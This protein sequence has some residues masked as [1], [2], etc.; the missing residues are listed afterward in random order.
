MD[1]PRAQGNK[2]ADKTSTQATKGLGMTSESSIKALILAELP[3]L[4]LDSPKYTEAQNQ[5]AKAEGAIK[6][7]K[8]WWE[9]PSGKLLV[10]EG[11]ART[12]VSQTH[13]ATHL[14]HD[15]LEE[16]IQKY[17]LVPPPP[18]FPMPDRISELHCLLT[19]QC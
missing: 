10:P 5:L 1:T 9:L 11:L 17:L 7:E 16:I 13:Q 14:G 6:T 15:K 12:L 18:T 2:L 8:R 19:G 3:E 4:K